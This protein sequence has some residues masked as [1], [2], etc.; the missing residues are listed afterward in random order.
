VVSATPYT[1]PSAPLYLEA[2]PVKNG[3]KLVWDAPL[4]NGLSTI[5]GYHVAVYTHNCATKVDDIYVLGSTTLDN[6]RTY[7]I[8]NGTARCFKVQASTYAGYGPLSNHAVAMAGRPTAP[9]PCS[10]VY[11]AGSD[12]AIVLWDEPSSWGGYTVSGYHAGYH[13]TYT[14]GQFSYDEWEWTDVT[15]HVWHDIPAGTWWAEI[16]AA[17]SQGDGLVCTTNTVTVP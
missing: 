3:I 12:Y 8:A 2:I 13:I 16:S 1:Y 4:S 11:S 6:T 14:D 15:S 10:V 7:S 5:I 9:A 17:N